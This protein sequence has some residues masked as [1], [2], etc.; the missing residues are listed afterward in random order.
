MKTPFHPSREGAERPVVL[1]KGE[2]Y[3][4]EQTSEI[5]VLRGAYLLIRGAS[6]DMRHYWALSV[7][8]LVHSH[9][10]L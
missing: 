4:G 3:E 1:E 6:L 5:P 2:A 8:V 10:I 9:D 7:H